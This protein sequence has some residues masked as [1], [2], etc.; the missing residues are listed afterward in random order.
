M[1][2]VKQ[3]LLKPL[4]LAQR[5]MFKVCSRCCVPLLFGICSKFA[6]AAA[7]MSSAAI[8]LRICDPIIK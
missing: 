5:D 8:K 3:Y 2:F 4:T 1:N 6:A 7:D